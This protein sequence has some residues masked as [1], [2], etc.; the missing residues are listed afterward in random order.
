MRTVI[1]ESFERIQTA[2]LSAWAAAAAFLEA[3]RLQASASTA[4]TFVQRFGQ[5]GSARRR[6]DRTKAMDDARFTGGAASTLHELEYFTLAASCIMCCGGSL[7]DGG[8]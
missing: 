1:A 4:G 3:K 6:G 5:I 7:P 2:Q 8:K